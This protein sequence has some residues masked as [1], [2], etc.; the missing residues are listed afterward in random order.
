MAPLK[1]ALDVYTSSAVQLQAQLFHLQPGRCDPM[2]SHPQTHQHLSCQTRN[3]VCPWLLNILQ[4]RGFVSIFQSAFSVKEICPQV[5]FH[6]FSQSLIT[7][8]LFSG[9]FQKQFLTLQ[10][11]TRNFTL[12]SWDACYK[13]HVWLRPKWFSYLFDRNWIWDFFVLFIVF[14]LC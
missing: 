14:L 5:V 3:G 1:R 4:I 2:G 11:L 13:F 8:S 10:P 6:L 9:H 7:G 12:S